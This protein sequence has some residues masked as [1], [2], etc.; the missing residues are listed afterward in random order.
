ML[1]NRKSYA[2]YAQAERQ[3]IGRRINS[4]RIKQAWQLA[5]IKAPPD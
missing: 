1:P 2:K 5:P 3:Q 4:R